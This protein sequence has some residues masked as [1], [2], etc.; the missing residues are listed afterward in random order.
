[1]DD[2][3][4]ENLINELIQKSVAK[5]DEKMEQEYNQNMIVEDP[6]EEQRPPAVIE[7]FTTHTDAVMSISIDPRNNR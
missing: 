2:P 7:R 6:Y 1:M 4:A 3:N 5:H